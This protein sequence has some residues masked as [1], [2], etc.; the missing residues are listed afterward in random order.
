MTR[1][2]KPSE[3]GSRLLVGVAGVDHEREPQLPCEL[4]LRVE[5]PQLLFGRCTIVVVVEAGL[6]HGDDPGVTEQLAELVDPVRLL[7][8][9]LVRIDSEHRP[10][11][12]LGCKRERR[13][14]RLDPG[15]DRDHARDA[16]F[17]GAGEQLAGGLVAAVEMRVGVDHAVAGAS[18]RGKSGCA[19]SIPVAATERP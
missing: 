9:R 16:G 17:A 14:R 11:A 5:E 7:P 8:T 3:R 1:P 15:S 6:A 18:I 4:D 2:S 19:A 12:V 13:P 10:H